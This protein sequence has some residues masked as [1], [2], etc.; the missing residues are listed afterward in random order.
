MKRKHNARP[1]ESDIHSILSAIDRQQLNIAEKLALS[2]TKRFPEFAFGW[3][4]LAVVFSQSNR[5]LDALKAAQR[6]VRLSNQDAEAHYNLGVI[7]GALGRYK[8]ALASYS[9]ATSLRFNYIDACLNQSVILVLLGE[10]ESAETQLKKLIETNPDCA[11]A[12]NNLANIFLDTQRVEEA[13]R[14]YANAIGHDPD[15]A[16]AHNGLGLV[17]MTLN[18]FE[19]AELSFVKA[20]A[21]RNQYAEAHSNLAAALKK[22][23]RFE[24]AE[25]HLKKAIS[26][27]S[28]YHEA[29]LALGSLYEDMGRLDEAL[30]SYQA[31]IACKRD[32]AQAHKQLSKLKNYVSRDQQ[33]H[34]MQN[35]AS[36]ETTTL[37]E[38]CHFRF[39]L[40]KACD[41]MGS[42]EEAFTHY[43]AANDFRRQLLGYVFDRDVKFFEKIRT[44]NYKIHGNTKKNNK[45]STEV[46]P[47]FILGLPRSGTTLVE[48]II[49]AH[50]MVYGGGELPFMN[51]L[52][53]S[54]IEDPDEIKVSTLVNLNTNYLCEVAKLANGKQFIT[55]KMPH[56]FRFIGL[57][58][59][60]FVDPI[61]IHVKRASS[62]VCWANFTQ[63]FA[64]LDLGYSCS[65]EDV[66]L[67]HGLYESLMTFWSQHYR[68]NMY[69]LEY[70][71]LTRNQED[72]TRKLIDYIGL[73][74][75][76]KCLHPQENKRLVSTASNL[77][78]RKKVYQGSSERWKSY[79]PFLGNL[80]DKLIS[81]N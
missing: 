10:L 71:E 6:V 27:S 50:P 80:F 23:S 21:L 17:F 58:N 77:Q 43:K 72:E 75:S 54:I 65:L 24:E 62:A 37:E 69:T 79:A 1:P 56:N 48:Q 52:G 12:H 63:D 2:M 57:I 41:D 68:Y 31:A 30:T 16:E 38:K 11:A 26:F 64:S 61:I 40:A 22:L 67:Y 53:R 73:N 74:W 32:Y 59:A 28:N 51:D 49:S 44:K 70:E 18:R 14:S 66:V 25:G 29:Y 39:A 33:F 35:F 45:L 4:A 34:D 20:I 55:D 36:K 5:Y 8:Q 13:R 46:R 7:F 3:K 81:T 76:D 60:A 19:E 47:I 9:F 78:I 42:Y 15:Y